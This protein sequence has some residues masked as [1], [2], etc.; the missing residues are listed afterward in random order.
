[1]SRGEEADFSGIVH[2]C[3]K[4]CIFLHDY[5]NK[6]RGLRLPGGKR[7]SLLTVFEELCFTLMVGEE[8][9]SF[10]A[11]IREDALA[12]SLNQAG[13]VYRYTLDCAGVRE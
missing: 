6:M 4:G 1:M 11:L 8:K 5:P 7:F 12:C 2:G 10:Y 13:S 3:L 9:T